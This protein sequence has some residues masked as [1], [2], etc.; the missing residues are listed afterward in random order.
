MWAALKKDS[1]KL[2]ETGNHI[3]IAVISIA[4]YENRL[5]PSTR[6]LI[7]GNLVNKIQGLQ[8]TIL[9]NMEVQHFNSLIYFMISY[10]VNSAAFLKCL[11]FI[12]TSRC[13]LFKIIQLK[14]MLK[15]ASRR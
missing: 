12:N 11:K 4:I 3:Q 9:P 7:P 1:Q 8:L 13:L 2:S 6:S 10:F 5:E 15:L 14:M